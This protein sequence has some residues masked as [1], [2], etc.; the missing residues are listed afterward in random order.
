MTASATHIKRMHDLWLASWEGLGARPVCSSLDGGVY[1][2]VPPDPEPITPQQVP[3]PTNM[4]LPL[5]RAIAKQAGGWAAIEDS[6]IAFSVKVV[7]SG[8]SSA[9]KPARVRDYAPGP[10]LDA[11]TAGSMVWYWCVLATGSNAVGAGAVPAS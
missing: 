3:V 10:A 2:V 9:K 1:T 6:S 11:G 7:G 5:S 8:G 4:G